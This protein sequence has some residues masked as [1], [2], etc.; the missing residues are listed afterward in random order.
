MD[1]I[2][3]LYQ[4]DAFT[5]KI[6]S[7]NPAGVWIGE[8]FPGHKVMLALA[9]EMNL[10]ET[11]FVECGN[12]GCRIRYFTP[13]REVPLC[14]HATLAA[15]H[16]LNE[17]GYI[18]DGEP[19]VLHASE[20]DLPVRVDAGWIQMTF[21]RY[22]LAKIEKA[23]HLGAVI[24][25]CVREAFRSDNGWIVARVS[26]EKSLHEARPDFPA[27]T[28]TGAALIAATSESS[29]PEYDYSVRV[30]CDPAYGIQE[31]PVTGAA[32]CILAP[33]WHAELG[34]TAFS[35]R[36]L[37][38]RGGEMKVELSAGGLLIKGQ[39]ATVFVI[40][41]RIPIATS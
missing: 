21:P 7:G 12:G 28:R 2:I 5:D 37:S 17:L 41:A 26:D 39:A 22:G 18:A 6:F 31:D 1:P 29:S 19:V 38:A 30:F 15:A 25:A 4:V 11:A 27:I 33:Y 36:Q 13:T 23:E 3:K 20:H 24:G 34:K 8:T 10:S 40:E 9:A 32:Q 16:I 35:S 14:G